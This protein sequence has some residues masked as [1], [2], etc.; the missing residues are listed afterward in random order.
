LEQKVNG[1]RG[2]RGL[3]GEGSGFGR[4]GSL[5]RLKMLEDV[6]GGE[7]MERFFASDADEGGMWQRFVK[8]P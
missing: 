3:G 8:T 5:G 2:D 7:R 6:P 4:R 1:G